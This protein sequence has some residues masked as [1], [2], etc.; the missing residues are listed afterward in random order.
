MNNDDDGDD[1]EEDGDDGLRG[2]TVLVFVVGIFAIAH[3]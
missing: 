1:E 3:G 2:N